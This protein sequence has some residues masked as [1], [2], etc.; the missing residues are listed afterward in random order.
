M[1]DP[2]SNIGHLKVKDK[3]IRVFDQSLPAKFVL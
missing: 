3:K 1:S 2:M